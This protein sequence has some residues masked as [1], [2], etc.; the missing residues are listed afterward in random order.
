MN[1]YLNIFRLKINTLNSFVRVYNLQK[2]KLIISVIQNQL[3]YI[4]L[5]DIIIEFYAQ[6]NV[7]TANYYESWLL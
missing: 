7:E 6:T 4:Q 5:A 1:S 2:L 3:K